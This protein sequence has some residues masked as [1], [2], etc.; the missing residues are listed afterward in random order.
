MSDT[1]D[2]VPTWVLSACRP[3]VH[4]L[5]AL[6]VGLDEQHLVAR[7][8]QLAVAYAA[9]AP[10]IA[11]D[12]VSAALYAALVLALDL[13]HVTARRILAG[14]TLHG[15]PAADLFPFRPSATAGVAAAASVSAAAF[16]PAP[17]R[18]PGAL[19]APAP[20]AAEVTDHAAQAALHVLEH[21]GQ[22]TFCDPE[23]ASLYAEACRRLG[24]FREGEEALA[25]T[26]QSQASGSSMAST[27]AA[28]VPP[29]LPDLHRA[30]P[31]DAQRLCQAASLALAGNRQGDAACAFRSVLECH[32]RW[33]WSAWTGYCDAGTDLRDEDDTELWTAAK[34]FSPLS[35]HAG[36]RVTDFLPPGLEARHEE[37][38]ALEEELAQLEK[39]SMAFPAAGPHPAGAAR[40]TKAAPAAAVTR[41]AST[42]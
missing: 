27:S 21:G 33:C 2:G 36:H 30:S 16:A 12:Y 26:L 29:P 42:Q 39:D 19:A 38:V 25:W 37:M 4:M 9:P 8:A 3:M 6:D 23:S 24:R 14:A 34:V 35:S 7:L 20:L 22:A 18:A 41:T 10:N 28:P 31:A 17:P 15:G 32:D 13:S 40:R 11:P 5:E 1:L